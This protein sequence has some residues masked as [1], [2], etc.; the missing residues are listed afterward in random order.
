MSD[1]KL[2]SDTP[3]F[4][5]FRCRD[6]NT[7]LYCLNCAE[8][9]LSSSLTQCQRE[10]EASKSIQHAEKLILLQEIEAHTA[11]KQER[12]HLQ[13]QNAESLNGNRPLAFDR[14]VF[15]QKVREIWIRWARA[16]P[17]PKPHWLTPWESLDEPDQE[18]DRVIGEEIARWAIIGDSAMRSFMADKRKDKETK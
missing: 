15:G 18:V 6:G 11:T 4:N 17:N 10:L 3:D 13:R 8:T 14:E 2:T 9:L 16:Q 5:C 12:D 1:K 7:F